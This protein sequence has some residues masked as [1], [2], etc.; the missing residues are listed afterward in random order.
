MN[1]VAKFP[2]LAGVLAL[3]AVGALC[4]GCVTPPQPP[5]NPR[6]LDF[7]QDGT[8]SKETVLLQLGQPSAQFESGRILT[9]RIGLE[10]DR[11]YFLRETGATNWLDLKFSLVLVFDGRDLLQR[12]AMVEVR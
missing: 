4:V 7:L 8:T 3:I 11:G 6:L 9:Y 12:H 2:T 10:K 1:S 5:A